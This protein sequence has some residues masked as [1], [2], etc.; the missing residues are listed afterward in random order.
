MPLDKI[1]IYVGCITH[2][3]YLVGIIYLYYIHIRQKCIVSL[4]QASPNSY[5]YALTHEATAYVFL[6]FIFTTCPLNLSRGNHLVIGSTAISIE[7][8][9]STLITPLF[10][11]Y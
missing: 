3:T 4:I 11:I 1:Y 10:T 8:I 5:D 9:N 6:N 2:T 7:E